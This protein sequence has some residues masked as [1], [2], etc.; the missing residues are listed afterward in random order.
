MLNLLRP[1]VRAVY[2]KRHP[3]FASLAAAQGYQVQEHTVQTSDG[4]L[5]TLHRVFE[6]EV[7]C[8]KGKPVAYFHH[9]LLTNSELFILGDRRDKCLPYLLLEKGYDVWL[10]NN[11]GNKY[12]SHI[13][14]TESDPCYWDFSLDE[15]A[16][17]D[18]P[19]IINYIL[20]FTGQPSLT[21]IGFSQGTTQMFAAMSINEDLNSKV[22]FFVALS[23]VMIPQ[24]LTH[25]LI[26]PFVQ[27]PSNITK[28]FGSGPLL[29]F[30]NLVNKAIPLPLYKTIIDVSLGILF[31]TSGANISSKQKLAGYPYLFSVSSVK[32]VVHWFQII[33]QQSFHKYYK[34]AVS[35]MTDDLWEVELFDMK[36]LKVPC[37]LVYGDAD[38]LVDID[39]TRQHFKQSNLDI[40]TIKVSGYEHMDTLWA[41]EVLY[42]VFAPVLE[43][44]E[45]A[46]KDRVQSTAGSVFI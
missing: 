25:P 14:L 18:I 41:D 39:K 6:K 26:K 21:Y 27:T 42:T 9:G 35:K 7:S 20:D 38:I 5:L 24:P 46:H 37:L 30:V 29:P 34:A 4:Y 19:S 45:E 22:N 36:N 17:T 33:R 1:I 10:G 23:P 44:I 3:D 8:Q 11:R 12:S 2:P 31:N 13:T 28:V 40:Q 16:H 32:C 15:F 43:K